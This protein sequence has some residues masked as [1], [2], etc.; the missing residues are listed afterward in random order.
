MTRIAQHR[1]AGP[2]RR[3]RSRVPLR[4]GGAPAWAGHQGW[5]RRGKRRRGAA[6]RRRLDL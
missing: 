5:A 4:L 3:H 1:V 6:Q 2:T